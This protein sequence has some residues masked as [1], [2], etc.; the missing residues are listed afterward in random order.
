MDGNRQYRE[1]TSAL[2]RVRAALAEI[3]ATADSPDG[4]VRATTDAHGR[5]LDLEL[6]RRIYRSTDSG[7]LTGTITATVQA[8]AEAAEA[9]IERIT[10]E[11]FA[12]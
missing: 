5:L 12:R 11:L 8:A 2:H 1:F 10:G 3:E 9:E 4:L 6:D 7:A